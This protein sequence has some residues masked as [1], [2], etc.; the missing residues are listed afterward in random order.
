MMHRT[1]HMQELWLHLMCFQ[2][3]SED[4]QAIDR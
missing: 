1:S 2:Y 3:S 4:V